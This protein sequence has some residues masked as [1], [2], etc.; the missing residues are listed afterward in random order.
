MLVEGLEGPFPHGCGPAAVPDEKE[1]E[2]GDF[3]KK[4][5]GGTIKNEAQDDIVPEGIVEK[6][7][8]KDES[9]ETGAKSSSQN[10]RLPVPGALPHNNDSDLA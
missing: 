2:S 6:E 5:E 3:V 7:Y 8:R 9:D 4:K 10:L 1:P